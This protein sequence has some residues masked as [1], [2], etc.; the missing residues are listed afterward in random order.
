M[1]DYDI[2]AEDEVTPLLFEFCDE[3]YA[4]V[5]TH[6]E[7]IMNKLFKNDYPIILSKLELLEKESITN[8]SKP[9]FWGDRVFFC[10]ITSL[11]NIT[12]NYVVLP[13]EIDPQ[14]HI[15]SV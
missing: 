3:I 12:V 9:E 2:Y 6:S 14:V 5:I 15:E 1:R 10:Y 13:T 4:L 8:I 7:I 11:G